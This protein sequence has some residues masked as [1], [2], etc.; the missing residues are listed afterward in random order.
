M[1]KT[2]KL[3]GA[4]L[5]A[6]VI[7]AVAAPGMASAA[8][9]N[10]SQGITDLF[11]LDRLFNIGNDATTGLGDLFILDKLF[12]VVQPA[13]VRVSLASQLS[14]RILLQ[15]EKNGEAW[16]VDPTDQNRRVFLNGPATAFS[17]MSGKAL[18]ISNADFDAFNGKAPARLAGRFLIKTEDLGKLYYVN[19]V[20]L[21]VNFVS[22]PAGAQALIAQFGLG[23][24]DSN[25]GQIAV[26]P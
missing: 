7:A 16:Y 9:F 21:S 20:D 10:R 6:G 4:I 23:I 25:L 1:S 22:G 26:A 18:G 5:A 2:K 19:P 12:P 15:V 13:V 24:T 8:T 11:V 17:I 3:A 14:G